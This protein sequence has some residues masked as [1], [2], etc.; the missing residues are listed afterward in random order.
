[1][2]LA[3]LLLAAA[4]LPPVPAHLSVSIQPDQL[5]VGDRT[6]VTLSLTVAADQLAGPPR[7]PVWKDSWGNARVLKAG[8]VRKVSKKN[9]EQVFEQSV[10]LV[11][12]STGKIPLPPRQIAVP[13][14][15]STA[16]VATPDEL[17]LHVRSV[18]PS[19]EEKGTKL[20]PKPP[21]P[22]RPLGL[23]AAF[24][25]T[26]AAGSLMVLAA[27]ALL[28]R[29][30][31]RAGAEGLTRPLKPPLEELEA[32]LNEARRE[33]DLDRLHTA[34]SLALRGYLGRV[35]SFSACDR[36]TREIRDELRNRRQ[37]EVW[38]RSCV[39][40]LLDCD[41][42]KFARHRAERSVAE[43][44]IARALEVGRALETRL[45]PVP[46]DVEKSA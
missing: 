18:L 9:G 28:Y 3:S 34:V 5:T 29:R 20:V 23:G 14:H 21:A 19:A 39:Q 42:V 22:P 10:T 11:P 12:F 44:R 32:R 26:G 33:T 46:A 24:W 30:R 25:W 15:S 45:R 38:S 1:M 13:F 8:P 7:F 16:E 37:P 36:T 6:E 43:D 2:M 41:Q 4:V 31:R 35:L 40:L 17:A 27:L